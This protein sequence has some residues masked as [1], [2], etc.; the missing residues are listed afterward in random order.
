MLAMSAVRLHAKRPEEATDVRR[1][2]TRNTVGPSHERVETLRARACTQAPFTPGAQETSGLERPRA[3]RIAEDLVTV[4]NVL[5]LSRMA[6]CPWIGWAVVTQRPYT[7]LGLLG[8]AA[9]TDLLDGFIARRWNSHT[10]FG[11]VADPAADKLLMATMV[12]SLS[13]GGQMPLPLAA[14]ILGR[15]FYLMCLAFYLRYRSLPEPRTWKRYWDPRYPSVQVVPTRISKY[16]TF[17]QL[18]LVALLT[19]YPCLPEAWQI[20][21]HVTRTRDTLAWIVAATT[22][23]TG[24][25]YARS[26]HAVRYLH[27]K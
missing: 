12:V 13:V 10:V 27:I 3:R 5:T 24:V 16:N 8:F 23:W 26:R 11:S 15:D 17:L 14:V 4:P 18:A 20:H 7:A 9:A 21:P 25:D 22:V 2:V 19:L 1:A 6:A